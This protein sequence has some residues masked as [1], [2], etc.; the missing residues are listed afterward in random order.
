MLP[1]LSTKNEAPK[2]FEH[3]VFTITPWHARILYECSQLVYSR[4]Y[5]VF[6]I[7][8]NIFLIWPWQNLKF[9]FQQYQHV[10][11]VEKKKIKYFFALANQKYSVNS[12]FSV[13]DILHSTNKIKSDSNFLSEGYKL[14]I[15]CRF[16]FRIMN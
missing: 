16:D 2:Y 3:T 10:E 8:A 9:I 14:L 12:N 4:I 13:I 1:I 7:N 11:S 5:F 15:H 6:V